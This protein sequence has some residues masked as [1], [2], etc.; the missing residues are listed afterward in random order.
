MLLDGAP[1]V[2]LNCPRFL[3]ARMT[4]GE[5]IKH[6]PLRSS[7]SKDR[8]RKAGHPFF[9]WADLSAAEGSCTFAKWCGEESKN[10]VPS[11]NADT[12]FVFF[13]SRS[14]GLRQ[15]K[16]PLAYEADGTVLLRKNGRP[17]DRRTVLHATACRGGSKKSAKR[18]QGWSKTS[19]CFP[20]GTAVITSA[21]GPTVSETTSCNEMNYSPFNERRRSPPCHENSDDISRKRR[22]HAPSETLSER[23]D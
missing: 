4:F 5:A 9:R 16:G 13:R 10:R 15:A 6:R 23:L 21:K 3:R 1:E 2:T 20:D 7:P 17:G 8:C 22:R 11:V 12:A 14:H 18:T 19:T